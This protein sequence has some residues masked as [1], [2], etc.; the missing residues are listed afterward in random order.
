MQ[1]TLATALLALAAAGPASAQLAPPSGRATPLAE[2]VL[3]TWAGPYQSESAPPGN[4]KLVVAREAGAWKV[5]LGVIADQELPGGEVRDFTVDEEKIS[6]V[7]E[8]MGMECK[9]VAKLE[10]GALKGETECSQGGA[11]AVTATFLLLRQ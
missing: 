2:Q 10:G 8:I 5:T 1:R 7:Q 6:W 11:V 4:L 9:S 3:G